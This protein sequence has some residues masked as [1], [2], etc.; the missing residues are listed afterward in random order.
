MSVFKQFK[1]SDIIIVPFEVNKGFYFIDEN[2]E[3]NKIYKYLGKNEDIDYNNPSYTLTTNGITQK[4]IYSSIKHLYYSNHTTSE[5]SDEI[6]LYTQVY[7]SENKNYELIGDKSS[8]GRYENYIQT[9]L[10]YP[11]LF[12][13]GSNDKIGVITIPKELF[14]NYIKPGSFKYTYN[15]EIFIDDS[16]GNIIRLSN[17]KF[18][19]RII[20][21]H[22]IIIITSN[23]ND[24]VSGYGIGTYGV[25]Y[26]EQS[27][28]SFISE[29]IEQSG[30]I[31]FSSSLT[32]QQTQYQCTIKENE[33]NYSYNKT[34][35]QDT[36][37]YELKSINNEDYFNVYSTTIGLYND[38]QELLA[39]AKLGQP[40]KLSKDYETNFIINL[41]R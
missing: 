26:Y 9:S 6:E 17:N 16:E 33:F 32:I 11:I 15:S 21:S 3:S 35:I 27:D 8:N 23:G 1:S 38:N 31:N 12:P 30:S 19:G 34:L 36:G 18:V 5:Y 41:D 39:V 37:S 7:D 13:T 29:F 2:F 22:G 28:N 24:V 20:Y 40:V 10:T 4:N 14:G 25:S